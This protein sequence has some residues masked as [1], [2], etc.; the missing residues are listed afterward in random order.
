MK[1]W[2]EAHKNPALI[3]SVSN[4]SVLEKTWQN[5]TTVNDE[6]PLYCL[7]GT[8]LSYVAQR[9]EAYR[10]EQISASCL[11]EQIHSK[12][13]T[14]ALYGSMPLLTKWGQGTGILRNFS[15]RVSLDQW[16]RA[17]S[18]STGAEKLASWQLPLMSS[19]SLLSADTRRRFILAKG[20]S[21]AFVPCLPP[22][23]CADNCLLC[24][25]L[26]K[27]LADTWDK[28]EIIVIRPRR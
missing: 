23:T 4:G 18:S 21:C 5:V 15:V 24:G 7:T 6:N 22:L 11:L 14:T 26:R 19:D 12:P 20:I 17:W 3:S 27:H 1:M 28:A 9:S 10:N 25:K 8:P 13:R 16:A 2:A